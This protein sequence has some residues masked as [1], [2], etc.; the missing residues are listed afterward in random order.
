MRNSPNFIHKSEHQ[1]LFALFTYAYNMK[2]GEEELA[3]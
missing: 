3:K 1:A 2:H